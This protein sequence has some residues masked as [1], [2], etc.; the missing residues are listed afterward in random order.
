MKLFASL[1]ALMFGASLAIAEEDLN[2]NTSQHNFQLQSNDWSLEIRTVL[3]D[4]YD[5][6]EVSKVLSNGLIASLRY[7]EDGT[8]T[9]I[10]PKLTQ[11]LFANDTWSLK[12]RMEYRYFEGAKTDD[13]WRYR[14]IIG[15]KSGNTW[16]KLEPRWELGGDKKNDGD[17]D[18]VKWQA[19]YNWSL[20]SNESSSIVLTPFVEYQTQG[21][22]GDWKKESMILGTNLSIKF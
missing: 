17:I 9:E 15:L 11:K 22:E 10:R 3:D 6:M 21:S 8:S 7:A 16:V 1:A 20:S 14:A 13:F 4:D 5:H 18:N 2:W 19:G 12:H